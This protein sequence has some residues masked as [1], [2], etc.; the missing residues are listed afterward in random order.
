MRERLGT[1]SMNTI[2]RHLVTWQGQQ[3]PAARKIG[4]P[5]PRLLAALGTEFSR[6]AEDAA[7][8]LNLDDED[9]SDMVEETEAAIRARRAEAVARRRRRCPRALRP[10]SPLPG[11]AQGA[12]LSRRRARHA[13]R[14]RRARRAP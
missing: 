12:P 10:R 4:D 2:H 14:R 9:R 13:L 3:K 5:N 6:V 1:G 11:R 8:E 7:A